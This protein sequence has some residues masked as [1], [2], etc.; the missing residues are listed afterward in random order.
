[1]N[2]F[3]E[4]LRL[5]LREKNMTMNELA[6]KSGISLVTIARLANGTRGKTLEKLPKMARAL[7]VSIDA[8]FPEMDDVQQEDAAQQAEA[9]T[10]D[11]DLEDLE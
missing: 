3:A 9:P 1:M 7:G 8:L 5:A 2:G 10:T 11:N 4:R 6:E